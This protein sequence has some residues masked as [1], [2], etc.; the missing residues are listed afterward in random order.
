MV[1]D[2]KFHLDARLSQKKPKR[3]GTANIHAAAE[4]G[5]RT[6]DNDDVSEGDRWKTDEDNKDMGSGAANG[7]AAGIAARRIMTSV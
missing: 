4:K 1:S 6:D 5:R 2:T 7:T 3:R